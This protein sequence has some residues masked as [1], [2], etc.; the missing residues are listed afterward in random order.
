MIYREATSTYWRS[1]PCP[2]GSYYSVS[3]SSAAGTHPSN[4]IS[5]PAWR[6]GTG[7]WGTLFHC[8]ARPVCGWSC[9][10]LGRCMKRG[11][12]GYTTECQVVQANPTPGQPLHLHR[13]R[14]AGWG[15]GAGG[16]PQG[17]QLCGRLLPAHPPPCST[18]GRT[19]PG[20]WDHHTHTHSAMVKASSK[21]C[22]RC[23]GLRAL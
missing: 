6:T 10:P 18:P 7:P 8:P 14:Q 2:P 17:S 20:R 19:G 13:R 3:C 21:F 22:R 4:H 16:S 1:L 15:G 9:Q 23:V 11:K 12:P 5:P